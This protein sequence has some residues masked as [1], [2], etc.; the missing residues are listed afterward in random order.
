MSMPARSMAHGAHAIRPP[1]LYV[2]HHE[3]ARPDAQE[4][5]SGVPVFVGFANADAPLPDRLRQWGI[6]F[7]QWDS[8]ALQ[9]L[10]APAAGSY[11][12]A[13]V[14]GFFANGGKRCVVL[15]VPRPTTVEGCRDALLQLLR[16][17]G[18]LDDRSD[19]DLVC[20]PDAAAASPAGGD[21]WHDVCAAALDHCEHMGDRFAILDAPR[22]WAGGGEDALPS[23]LHAA[24]SLR[25]AFGALYFPWIAADPSR[26]QRIHSIGTEQWRC[27]SAESAVAAGALGFLPPCGHVAGLYARM[28]SAIGVQQSPA[29]EAIEGAVDTSLRLTDDQHALLNEAGVNALRALRGRGVWVGGARTLSGHA[30]WTHIST[31][32]VVLDFK[33]WLAHGLR[34]V[35]FEPQTQDL[36]EHIRIRLVSR[37]LAMQSKGALAG[38]AAAPGFFVKCDAETNP[39]D[40][41]ELGRVVAHVGLAPQVPAEFILIRVVHDASGF[42]VSGLS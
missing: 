31:A 15:A 35:V 25:S 3:R 30:G 33:R 40:E 6:A 7:D 19:I 5:Q 16:R 39:I 37:C 34:D 8:G 2:E 36:W 11:L 4:W 20:I 38:S 14:R 41:R 10:V 9:Q 23:M 29:N 24:G 27:P 12:A 32:R 1:G 13:S 26:A 18:P 21:G 22:E 28:D 17:D 42:T